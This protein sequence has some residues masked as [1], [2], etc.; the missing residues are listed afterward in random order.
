M[1]N[2]FKILLA[3]LVVNLMLFSG[4]TKDW[5]DV[6]EDPNNPKTA[7]PELVLPAGQMSIG[8]VVG[9]HY[10][11]VGGFWSQYWSQ[12]NAANQYKFIDQYQIQDNSAPN[13]RAW[14]EAYGNGLSD[15]QY[16][17]NSTRASENWSIF[18]M[19]T[20]MQCYAWQVLVDFMDDVPYSQAFQ[21]DA[22]TANYS[23]VFDQGEAIYAHV[24]ARIDSAL[25]KPL[26]ELTEAEEKGDFLY[27]G[28]TEAWIKFANT[29]K[30][31]MYIR[32]MYANPTEAQAGI[33]ALYA[34]GAE[35]I[36]TL[37]DEAKLDIFIDQE[38]K[39]NPLYANNNRKLNVATNLRVSA[40]LYRYLET[41]SDPRLGEFVS[42]NSNPMPQGGFN[43]PT[44]QLDPTTV[45]IFRNSPTD[46]VY[47]ISA[48]E[49]NLLQAEA[50]ARGWGTGDAKEF[51][52]E[53][54]S[55]SFERYDLDA[56]DFIAADG[57]YEYPSAGTFEEQ[58]EAIMMAKWAALAGTQGIEMF[59]ETNRT[60][61]PRVST[62]PAWSNGAYN[63]DYEG[64]ALTYS[65]EGITGGVFPASFVYP[66]EEVNL[67]ENFPGQRSVTDK[68]WWDVK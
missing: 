46:P 64:G 59:F 21:G 33:E 42:A 52:D 4:C 61:Y 6:N 30:L 56:T 55:L 15:L 47:F 58:Q 62:I 37:E 32:M 36:S 8:T 60:G 49:S 19:A 25:S 26:N 65:L 38:G 43:I 41:N 40:T 24:L 10:N 14:R 34:D 54:I 57:V 13:N 63:T 2:K 9:F 51:Y 45:A 39:D 11:L 27:G 3:F 31:K 1:K 68:V 17:I 29:L 12:S 44:P 67:N 5:L 28:D 48:V 16:V 66:Q 18:L 50:I 23:P 22:A 7:N 20:V 35:F 53:A